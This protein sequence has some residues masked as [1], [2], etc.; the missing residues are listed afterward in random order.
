MKHFVYLKFTKGASGQEMLRLMTDTMEGLLTEV[1]G[2]QSYQL[3]QSESS[4][5]NGNTFLIE[6]TFSDDDA[7]AQYLSH[8]MHLTML[9]QICSQLVDKAAFDR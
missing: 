8:P 4:L 3:M 2:F 5:E 1:A 6:L 9:H 7:K